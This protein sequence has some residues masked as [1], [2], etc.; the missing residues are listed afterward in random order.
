MVSFGLAMFGMAVSGSAQHRRTP[1]LIELFTS[2]GCSSCPPADHVLARLEAEQP[3]AGAEIIVL[4]EHVDYWNRLGWTDPFSSPLFTE[5]QRRYTL[6]LRSDAYTPQMIVNGRTVFV[7]SDERR[8]RREVEKA[9]PAT[10]FP[11]LRVDKQ[12]AG[13]V[14][15]QVSA[16]GIPKQ[17]GL[18]L[19]VTESGLARDV[20]SGENGGRR[21]THTGVVRSLQGVKVEASQTATLAVSLKS[22]WKIE[23]LRL[24]AF[25][26]DRDSLAILG[27]TS[28]PLILPPAGGGSARV[29]NGLRGQ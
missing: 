11:E 26:Q 29:P 1:V 2:Q 5:R 28:V 14:K 7:G 6:Q 16:T 8:A 17:A 15:V 21:L 12:E 3:V 20:R 10:V 24:V 27:A 18:W 13:L 19:A 23:N 25:V 9:A 4:S 22:D